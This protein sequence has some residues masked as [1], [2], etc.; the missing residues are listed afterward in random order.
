M[1]EISHTAHVEFARLCNLAHLDKT[2]V[3]QHLRTFGLFNVAMFVSLN[4]VFEQ[5]LN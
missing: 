5:H 3:S 2:G 4:L 1:R